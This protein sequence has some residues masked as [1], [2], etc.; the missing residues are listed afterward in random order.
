MPQDANVT[1]DSKHTAW[2]QDPERKEIVDRIREDL[3]ELR[4]ASPSGAETIMARID[5]ELLQVLMSPEERALKMPI[6]GAGT[7]PRAAGRNPPGPA[8]PPGVAFPVGVD[9]RDRSQDG[10]RAPVPVAPASPADIHEWQRGQIT[11]KGDVKTDQPLQMGVHHDP[12]AEKRRLDDEATHV[13]EVHEQIKAANQGGPEENQRQAELDQAEAERKR[14]LTE[15]MHSPRQAQNP[16][17]APGVAQE[18]EK[19][20]LEREERE[21]LQE[22][23]DRRAAAGMPTNAPKQPVP[24]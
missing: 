16:N 24:A 13:K 17:P 9:V 4:R 1:E 10:T 6:P 12:E 21:R 23:A 7:N 8:T 3:A 22:N 20:R 2:E 15:E 14:Q 19:N 18:T 11:P 5:A